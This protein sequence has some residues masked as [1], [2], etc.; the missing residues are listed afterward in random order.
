[1]NLAAQRSTLYFK[2][3]VEVVNSQVSRTPDPSSV[4]KDRRYVILQFSEVLNANQRRTFEQHGVRFL[5]YIPDQAYYVSMP[6]NLDPG[7]ISLSIQLQSILPLQ[8]HHKISEGLREN[9]SQRLTSLWLENQNER[10]RIRVLFITGLDS[11]DV[12]EILESNGILSAEIPLPGFPMFEV[13]AN[14]E[15]IEVLSA[16]P[17]IVWLDLPPGPEVAHRYVAVKNE[18]VEALYSPDIDLHGD[19]I[20]IGVG[21]AGKAGDHIDLNGHVTNYSPSAVHFHVTHVSGIIAGRPNLDPFRGQGIAP[22]ANIV[23]AFFS[24]IIADSERFMTDYHMLITNNSYGSSQGSCTVA[25]DYNLNSIFIDEQL[26]EYDSL[27]H[28]F[29]AGNDGGLNCSPYPPRFHTVVN[30]WQSAKNTLVVG[31]LNH[32]DA[33][34]DNSSRGPVDDGRIKPEIMAVG[35]NVWS[36]QPGN[37]YMTGAG[38][39][40]S[41]PAITG[42]CALL[43][44]AY[45][46]QQGGSPDAALIK[47]LLL[48][49][50]DDLGLA[51]PDFLFGYGRVNAKQAYDALTAET[52]FTGQV[53]QNEEIDFMLNVPSGTAELRIM[54]LWKDPAAAPY[55]A[56]ALVNDLDLLVTNPSATTF[57]PWVL[58][59]SP[60]GCALQATRGIDDKNPQE[61]VTIANPVSG[62]Y[63]LSVDGSEVP[64]GPQN[65][66]LFYEII[67]HQIEVV[68]PNGG[69]SLVPGETEYVRWDA[70]GSAI[71]N[72]IVEYSLDP[73]SNWT[74]IDNNVLSSLRLRSFVVPTNVTDQFRVRVT[75]GAFQD[76]S[77]TTALVLRVP[78][79]YTLTSPC[80]GYA[81]MTW[82]AVTGADHYAIYQLIDGWMQQIDTASATS[83]LIG[84]LDPAITEWYT[85]ATVH[86]SD[87]QSR[88]ATARSIL[89]TGLLQCLWM[90][91]VS[92]DAM[93]RPGNGRKFTSSSLS[94]SDTIRVTVRNSGS[95][96]VSNIPILFRINNGMIQPG[97][98]AGTLAAGAS[99]IYKFLTPVDLSSAG[100][101]DIEVWTTLSG[102]VHAENDTIT[103]L[104]RHIANNPVTL[105][106]TEGFES[107]N[108]LVVKMDQFAIPGIESCDFNFSTGLGR[109]RT[110]ASGEFIANGNRALTLDALQYGTTSTNF[111]KITVNMSAYDTLTDD[112]RLT[113][114]YMHHVLFPEGDDMN[115]CWVRGSEADPWI[116]MLDFDDLT[117]KRGEYLSVFP[118]LLITDSLRQ[119]EQN[120]STSFQL[121]FT[122]QGNA[123][124]D[125]TIMEDGYT[126]DN[127]HLFVVTNDLRITALENPI[128]S[129]CGLE[130]ESISIAI[131]NTSNTILSDVEVS[132]QVDD[133]DVITEQIAMIPAG[134][135]ILHVFSE[136]YAFEQDTSYEVVVWLHHPMDS[137]LQNDTVRT[138]VNSSIFISAFPYL[139]DFEEGDG[140]WYAEGVNSTLALGSPKGTFI[141]KAASGTQA[142]V[143]GLNG[144]HN[145]DEETYLIS[146]CFDLTS[147]TNPV[148][149]FS[150]IYDTETDFDFHWVEYSTDGIHWITLGSTS[151]GFN[152][153]NNTTAN[154]PQA[155]EGTSD[156]WHVASIGL[157]AEAPRLQIRFVFVSDVGVTEE[158]FGIDDVHIHEDVSIY[159]GPNLLNAS[160]NVNGTDWVWIDHGG[161][162]IMGI[163]PMGQNL[164]ATNISMYQSN[165]ETT[166]EGEAWILDKNWV[167]QPTNAPVSP[168]KVRLFLTEADFDALKLEAAQIGNGCPDCIPITDVYEMEG[169]KYS[170]ANEDN[171]LNNNT[172]GTTTHYLDEQVMIVPYDSGYYAE[173]MIASL[174][175]LWLTGPRI[176]YVDS[177]WY[178][179]TTSSDDAEE[180]GITGSVNP[181][182]PILDISEIPDS[183]TVGLRFRNIEIPD[184][185][186][187]EEAYLQFT[188]AASDT[189]P[190]VMTILAEEPVSANAFT[191]RHFNVTS[192]SD[193]EQKQTWNI[194]SWSSGNAGVAQRS[195]DIRALVQELVDGSW[196]PGNA[197]AF[198]L[199][200]LGL[201]RAWSIDGDEVLAPRLHI[202]YDS[203]CS[204]EGILYV[205]PT[206][207]GIANGE[208]WINA[209]TDLQHALD[210]AMRCPDA[211][212]IWVKE[213]VYKTSSFESFAIASGIELYGGF[214]GNETLRTQRDP[215]LNP[216]ILSGDIGVQG[217]IADNNLHVVRILTGN[218]TT[219]VDGFTIEKGNAQTTVNK[220]GGIFSEGHCILRNLIITGCQSIGGGSA[221]AHRGSGNVMLIS[222]SVLQNN[223]GIDLLNETGAVMR[224]DEGTVTVE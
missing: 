65:F 199:T 67:G 105:P 35:T 215:V 106:W 110:N 7:S 50:A 57:Q 222:N 77:D 53:D 45:Q 177:V 5:H 68:Y 86:D 150:H 88:R 166:A 121:R 192:R 151:T 142:W 62:M 74:V 43:Y 198:T 4:Y 124:A 17:A 200:G 84:G 123:S 220:G 116:E 216:T 42:I 82:T 102:D 87:K 55:A 61:Q 159:T 206:A 37:I 56:P 182:S 211:K 156:S 89:P 221:I 175:E 118:E 40:Y 72:Y 113:F 78:T 76:V 130:N 83:F 92:I 79:G 140:G 96:T 168:V 98:I 171:T 115:R 69:E 186:F 178:K 120:F 154:T 81:Q 18:R 104:V 132:Y 157:P 173:I 109:L 60:A 38:T 47:G 224:V 141:S 146:P 190:A 58:N 64:F 20:T 46:Q 8:S 193:T 9:L 185:S 162:R 75:A 26:V 52:Y 125:N 48:N 34:H 63:T 39:S 195:T 15:D 44:Q 71:Q 49:T 210:L 204:R 19:G 197:I 203:V 153:Y 135:N 207:T 191:T 180:Y 31:M 97:M 170:G 152:W 107:S 14:D 219:V 30:G 25:G 23:T 27:M 80:R 126:I 85:V 187:I 2:N 148:L 188:A 119:R 165:P 127:V 51:G 181:V 111:L 117:V 143:T 131:E 99:V 133:G 214:I 21:D 209:F 129:S 90:N 183:Q 202:R 73:N 33:I 28:V 59:P 205:D 24:Q 223:T 161:H 108:D 12:E 184:G 138:I 136:E 189:D 128:P 164:G 167:I 155:W 213:G 145:D 66:Y 169:W 163:H 10:R 29:S 41:G 179:V 217:N 208:S 112:V 122:Q 22:E 1:M 144:G 6:A 160:H 54:L 93:I 100:N 91:D 16:H 70:T 134:A 114:D 147:L 11:N 3:G 13:L 103:R 158:G 194:A 176:S 174:S 212:E 137:Y 95:N 218:D 36:T 201:R 172:S 149:S 101:Y 196:S 139:E 94:A 32:L